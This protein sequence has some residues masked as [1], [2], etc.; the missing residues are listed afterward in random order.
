MEQ[1]NLREQVVEMCEAKGLK[2]I[3]IADKIRVSKSIMSKWIH[4]KYKL[5]DNACLR[6]EKLLKQYN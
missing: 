2:Y 1:Q 3:F 4:N 5:N 6:L